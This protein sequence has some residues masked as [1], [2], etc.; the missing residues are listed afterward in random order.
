VLEQRTEFAV[1]N[2]DPEISNTSLEIGDP[3]RAH[4]PAP[5]PET[6]QAR[7]A[8]TQPCRSVE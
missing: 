2:N 4:P 7:Y 1:R 6:A 5:V 3:S 8:A